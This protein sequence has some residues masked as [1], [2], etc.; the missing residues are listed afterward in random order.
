MINDVSSATAAARD[1]LIS[2]PILIHLINQNRHKTVHWAATMFLLQARKMATGM[3][4]LRYILILIARM[5]AL[6]GLIFAVSR[7]L[8]GGWLALTAGG[9]PDTT[10]IILDR[11]ASMEQ[12][13]PA[14]GRSKRGTAIEKLARLLTES[15]GATQLVLIDSVSGR[16]TPLESPSNLL[17]SPLTSDSATAADLPSLLQSAADYISANQ[18]GRTDIWI[19]SDL[20]ESDWNADS[21]RWEAIRSMFSD[22]QGIRFQLLTYTEPAKNNLAVSVRNVHRRASADSAELVMD[23]RI[24]RSMAVDRPIRI[25]VTLMINGAKTTTDLELSGDTLQL[26]GFVSTIDR[27]A[28]TGWGRIELPQDDNPADNIFTFVYAE[29]EVHRTAIVSDNPEIAEPFRLAAST[30]Q[31]RGQNC[32]ASIFT[33]TQAPQ[34]PWDQTALLIWMADF[35]NADVADSMQLFVASGRS[36]LFVPPSTTSA[37]SFAGFS[38]GSWKSAAEGQKFSMSQWRTDSDL[39][40]NARSGSPLPVNRIEVLQYCPLETGSTARLQHCGDWQHC[41]ERPAS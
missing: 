14:S 16:A 28:V 40:A 26:N 11:S 38:W 5:L 24:T 17:D 12:T 23:I 35:P 33:T 7:P 9:M 25:P 1:S 31:Q 19:C 8:A 4:R 15:G 30:P 29:P 32:E 13:D 21:G 36:I 2:L 20:Q 22:L 39:L 27:N 3:A 10:L 6:A 34:L 18:T 41:G 37:K